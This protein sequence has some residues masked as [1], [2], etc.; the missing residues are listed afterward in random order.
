MTEAM[1]MFLL[2]E[3]SIF[4]LI[5]IL[6]PEEAMKPYKRRE[7]PPVTQAGIVIVRVMRGVMKPKQIA[8]AQAKRITLTEAIFVTPTTAT[9]SP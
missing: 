4:S 1:K 9:F 6:T 3:K 5:I 8:I 7:T 2:L